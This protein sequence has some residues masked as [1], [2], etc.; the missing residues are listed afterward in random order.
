MVLAMTKIMLQMI[1]LGFEDI[2][3][4]ILAFPPGSRRRH[5]LCHGRV[6]DRM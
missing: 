6:I 3:V 2:V 1:A 5:D 4:F